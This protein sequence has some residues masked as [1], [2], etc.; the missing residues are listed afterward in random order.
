MRVALLTGV[1][2]SCPAG[3]DPSRPR[4]PPPPDTS[5]LHVIEVHGHRGARAARPENTMAAFAYAVEVGADV[6]EMDVV[7]TADDVPIVHHD[8]E[9][10]PA[11]CR[12]R[13]GSPILA[14]RAVR[15]LTRAQVQELDCGSQ[16]HPDF[17]MQ[18]LVPGEGIPTL[19]DVLSWAMNRPDAASRPIRLNI[20]AK[21]LPSRPE[22]APAPDAF[23]TL[24]I[25]AL[26]T[27]GAAPIATVQSFDHRILNAIHRKFPEL[28]LAALTHRS[29]PDLVAVARAANAGTLSPHIDW[30]TREDAL[31]ARA[32]DLRIVPWTANDPATWDRLIDLGVDGIITDDPAGLRRHLRRRATPAPPPE[33]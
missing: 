5:R 30:I 27:S 2:A 16:P 28:P 20:E 23:A 10:D 9:I 21:S 18:M 24:L 11:R 29:L 14:G 33:R 17:P 32:A 26:R 3:A 15:S 4:Q 6:L 7:V 8:L 1:A 19:A 12:H 31:A 22:L 25:D 13:D